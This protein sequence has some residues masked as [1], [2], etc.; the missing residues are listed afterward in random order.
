VGLGQAETDD[1][2]DED[3]QQ[4]KAPHN[5]QLA[6]ARGYR[7]V[8]VHAVIGVTGVTQKNHTRVRNINLITVISMIACIILVPRIYLAMDTG[9]IALWKVLHMATVGLTLASLILHI[10][11]AVR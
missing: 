11:F 9:N 6:D 8:L 7:H 3:A 5:I 4:S 1:V 2:H 10:L